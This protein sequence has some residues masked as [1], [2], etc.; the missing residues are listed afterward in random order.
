M[1]QIEQLTINWNYHF[2]QRYWAAQDNG[3]PMSINR[4]INSQ[5]VMG[6]KR[7]TIQCNV[8][9]KSLFKSIVTSTHLNN[10]EHLHIQTQT[11]P[12]HALQYLANAPQLQQLKTLAIQQRIDGPSFDSRKQESTTLI[13]KLNDT[14]LEHLSLEGIALTT[15]AIRTLMHNIMPK[16]DTLNLKHNGLNDQDMLILLLNPPKWFVQLKTIRLN[17]SLR[18]T[19]K[20]I[21]S[22][23]SSS[24]P[25]L[26][27][28]DL[29]GN[30]SLTHLAKKHIDQSTTLPRLKHV[31]WPANLIQ[32]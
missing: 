16:L 32:D 17:Q 1:S 19:D 2:A 13:E 30:Q 26:E 20:S 6:L 31:I 25:N 18:L 28:L 9:S 3:H 8:P 23:A 22:L 12:T 10:L 24:L 21:Q 7:F 11:L 4:L 27:H 5:S 15:H 14:H 29:T